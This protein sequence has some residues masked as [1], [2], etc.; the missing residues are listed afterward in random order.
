MWP[1]VRLQNVEEQVSVCGVEG[2]KEDKTG[3]NRVKE[4][5]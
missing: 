1:W 2:E 3:K 4:W 5:K